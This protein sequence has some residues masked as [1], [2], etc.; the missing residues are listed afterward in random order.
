MYICFILSWVSWYILFTLNLPSWAY[1]KKNLFKKIAWLVILTEHAGKLKK[2]NNNVKSEYRQGCPGI[3]ITHKQ[4]FRIVIRW[5]G[6]VRRVWHYRCTEHVVW[7]DR[8]ILEHLSKSYFVEYV[9]YL[10]AIPGIAP[11][12]DMKAQDTERLC[13]ASKLQELE[14]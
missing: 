3:S 2:K 1:Q 14:T 5:K 7:G 9:L 12:E 10:R 4:P 13:V 8:L 6:E 11:P